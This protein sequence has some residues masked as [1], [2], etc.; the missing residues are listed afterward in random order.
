MGSTICC[1]PRPE[2]DQEEAPPEARPGSGRSRNLPTLLPDPSPDGVRSRFDPD[3]GIVYY[4]EN[5][6]DYLMIKESEQA[7]LDY[8]ATLVAK[9]YV[10]YNNPR[11]EPNDLAEEM[12]RMVVR[13]RRHLPRRS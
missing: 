2:E 13:V 1:R 11:A 4:N 5:H 8:L 3:Q 9:E 10:V 7:L 12:V 6:P